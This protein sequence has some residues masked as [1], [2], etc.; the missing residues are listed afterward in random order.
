MK[1]EDIAHRKA[2][3]ARKK[4]LLMIQHKNEKTMVNNQIQ[5]QRTEMLSKVQAQVQMIREEEIAVK[6]Q[7]IRV[8]QRNKL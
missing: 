1:E 6:I 4:A 2:E 8:D 7:K 3:D 5:Q